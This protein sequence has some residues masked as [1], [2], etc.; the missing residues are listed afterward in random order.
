MQL[1][2]Q[3]G[4]KI[5]GLCRADLAPI[6]ENDR[7]PIQKRVDSLGSGN[8]LDRQTATVKLKRSGPVA[9]PILRH[10]LESKLPLELKQRKR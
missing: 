8:C 9:I 3:Y 1:L 6:T 5:I 4:D 2:A 10:A 7:K